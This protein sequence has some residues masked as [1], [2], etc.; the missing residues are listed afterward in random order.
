MAEVKT[1]PEALKLLHDVNGRLEGIESDVVRKEE[2]EKVRA[3]LD[4]AVKTLG[5][6][7]KTKSN[8]TFEAANDV[9]L[10]KEEQASPR[11]AFYKCMSKKAKPGSDLQRYQELND[12]LV[13]MS[14]AAKGLKDDTPELMAKIRNSEMAQ[15][16]RALD[17]KY[18]GKAAMDTTSESEWVPAEILSGNLIDSVRNA[19]QLGPLFWNFTMPNKTFKM[20]LITADATTYLIAEATVAP[21]DSGWARITSSQPTTAQATWGAV[22]LANRIVFSTEFLEEATPEIMSWTQDHAIVKIAEG[23]DDAIMNGDTASTHQDTNV[24]AATDRRKAWL[25]LRAHAMDQSYSTDMSRQ[26]RR[27]PRCAW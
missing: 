16:Y 14:T 23:K 9:F 18:R 20:P 13:L 24:T 25:G 19:Q 12:G 3:D 21:E 10:T 1:G 27:G 6:L 8:P 11:K 2:L 7:Q 17:E 5:E 22:K 4:L 15:E 26:V